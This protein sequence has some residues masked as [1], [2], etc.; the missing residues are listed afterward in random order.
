MQEVR[1]PGGSIEDGADQSV[2]SKNK[3]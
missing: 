1:E 3:S 2:W